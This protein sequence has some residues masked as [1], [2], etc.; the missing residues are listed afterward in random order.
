MKLISM[1]EF[2]LDTKQNL[3]I[4]NIDFLSIQSFHTLSRLQVLI[5]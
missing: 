4:E 2:V 1:T 3:E 5:L